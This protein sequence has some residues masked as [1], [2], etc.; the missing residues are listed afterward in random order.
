[1]NQ[2]IH[3]FFLFLF[4]AS[5]TFS[6]SQTTDKP[7]VQTEVRAD[8]FRGENDGEK[9][10]LLFEDNV[11]LTATNMELKCNRLEVFTLLKNDESDQP[12]GKVAIGVFSSIEKIIASGGVEIIQAERY[13]TSEVAEVEPNEER[14]VLSG[15][16]IVE[17]AGWRF[18]NPKGQLILDRGNGRISAPGEE[19]VQI[20]IIGPPIGDLGFELDEEPEDTPPDSDEESEEKSTSPEDNKPEADI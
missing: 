11:V 17:Q 7:L 5:A 16:P 9:A 15:S 18:S 6:Y 10:Y 8:R 19:N 12:Q 14:V 4:L 13:A 1:M 20:Q 2:P 3:T